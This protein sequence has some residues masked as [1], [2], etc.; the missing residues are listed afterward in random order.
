VSF[1]YSISWA[2]G[3]RDY[4]RFL[5][6]DTTAPGQFQDE[7]LD[8]LLAQQGNDA[9]MAAAAALDA[10][11]TT[12]SRSAISYSVTGFSMDRRSVAAEMRKMATALRDE[13]LR[14][15]YEWESVV[16]HYV[17]LYGED[18]SNYINSPIEGGVRWTS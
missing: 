13:A 7:E 15:P 8:A 16:D 17:S 18:W 2:S 6:G 11:A 10:W 3:S 5:I 1:T 12:L 4:V 14:E 9:R